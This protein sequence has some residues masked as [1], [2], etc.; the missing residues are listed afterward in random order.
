MTMHRITS[1]AGWYQVD[2][3]SADGTV[4]PIGNFRTEADAREWLDTY[5]R[6]QTRRIQTGAEIFKVGYSVL[7]AAAATAL[8]AAVPALARTEESVATSESR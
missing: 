8:R 6:M 2:E 4:T 1:L 3:T 5:L 7:P